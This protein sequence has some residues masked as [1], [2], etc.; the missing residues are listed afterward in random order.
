MFLIRRKMILKVWLAMVCMKDCFLYML[1]NSSMWEMMVKCC[2]IHA[3]SM[4]VIHM[5]H[6]SFTSCMLH[7]GCVQITC[8]LHPMYMTHCLNKSSSDAI[9]SKDVPTTY[10]PYTQ[11]NKR[12]RLFPKLQ[13]NMC[14][15][16]NMRL[17]MK[18]NDHT[19][20]RDTCLVVRVTWQKSRVVE[21]VDIVPL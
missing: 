14:L 20:N 12:I 4:Y 17:I 10:I 6:E 11:V 2:I 5:S 1:H 18:S 19:P 13:G 8:K 7:A 21:V 16:P 9:I 3:Q 15:L